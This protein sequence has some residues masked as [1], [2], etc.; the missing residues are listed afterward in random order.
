M[1]DRMID[2]IELKLCLRNCKNNKSPGPDNIF[3]EFLKNSPE[4]PL[5]FLMTVY[6][7]I[8][9]EEKVPSDWSTISLKISVGLQLCGT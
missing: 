5:N 1:L 9:M 3:Y 4:S 6:N 2:L 7:N 8:L